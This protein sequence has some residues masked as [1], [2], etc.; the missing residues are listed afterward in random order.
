MAPNK[1]IKDQIFVL[2]ESI[3]SKTDS[4][5]SYSGRIPTLE[6]DMVKEDIRKLYEQ[7][8]LLEKISVEQISPNRFE[9]PKLEKPAP[10]VEV[11]EE[12]PEVKVPEP[13]P[14][15]AKVEA[16]PE[17]PVVEAKPEVK[18]EPK[19]KKQPKVIEEKKEV[20]EKK[21][22]VPPV[23]KEEPIVVEKS[24]PEPKSEPKP[25]K[26]AAPVEEPAKEILAD[27]YSSQKSLNDLIAARKSD[28]S[29]S[30]KMRQNPITNLKS[31]IGVN[32][33]FIFVYELFGG[34]MNRFNEIVELLN[35]RS[36]LEDAIVTLEEIKA[37]HGWDIEN[38]AFQKLVDMVNRRYS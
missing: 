2:I 5:T 25:V 4:L 36:N 21:E 10:K 34:N 7:I 22:V 33:K 19:P 6:I 38:A 20:I 30:S 27:K 24:K 17:P 23:V 29:I 11:I 8:N 28:K 32:E 35:T 18:E 12:K 16:A 9:A 1:H 13:E 31:A 3:V 37:E 26:E 14:V 15:K